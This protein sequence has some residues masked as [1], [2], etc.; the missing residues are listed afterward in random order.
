MRALE[1][2]GIA[3]AIESAL[4]GIEIKEGLAQDF[5][6]ERAVEALLLAQRLR[7]VRARMRHPHSEAYQPSHQ[8]RVGMIGAIAPRRTVIHRHALGQPVTPESGGQACLHS[9]PALIGAGLQ[10]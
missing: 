6:F 2:V 4:Q 9:R 7:M 1:V 10:T 8:W 3:P 5:S